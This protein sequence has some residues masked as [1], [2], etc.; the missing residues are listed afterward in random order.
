MR[1]KINKWTIGIVEG[2]KE[3][4]TLNGKMLLEECGGIA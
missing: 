3:D 1:E 2:E 4:Q